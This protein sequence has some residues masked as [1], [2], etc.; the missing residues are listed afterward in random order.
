MPLKSAAKVHVFAFFE[1]LSAIS[2]LPAYQFDSTFA[3][4][5][6]PTMPKGKQQKIVARIDSINHVFGGGSLLLSG[7]EPWASGVL[8][9]GLPQFGQLAASE[10]T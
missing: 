4:Y 7:F 6:I 5:T 8:L 3:A 2:L 1:A 10:D 9:R